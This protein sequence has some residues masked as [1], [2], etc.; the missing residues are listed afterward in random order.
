MKLQCEMTALRAGGIIKVHANLSI[1]PRAD[2]AFDRDD[3][4]LVPFAVL[5]VRL[6]GLL[7]QQRT[8]VLLVKLPPPA[9]SD[10][11]LITSGFRFAE[12]LAAELNAAVAFVIHE[13]DL[14][15]EPEVDSNHV[16]EE[17]RVVR[18]P[19]RRSD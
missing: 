7:P 11:S 3:L 15:R 12:Q 16:T 14:D 1:N 5:D 8:P 6:A 10:V 9:R 13:L 17:E 19:L 2:P 18:K 4:I